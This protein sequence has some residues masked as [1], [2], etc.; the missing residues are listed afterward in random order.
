M[1]NSATQYGDQLVLMGRGGERTGTIILNGGEFLGH[2]RNFIVVRFGDQVCTFDENETILGAVN[3]DESFKISG[4]TDS[5][6]YAKTGS[7]VEVYDWYCN[8]IDHYTV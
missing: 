1:I 7:V 5:G 8:H 3:L 6:F 2:S 4:I